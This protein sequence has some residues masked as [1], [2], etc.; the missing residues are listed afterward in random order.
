METPAY[1]DHR[2]HRGPSDSN[3]ANVEVTPIDE[4][5]RHGVSVTNDLARH[6]IFLRK[7]REKLN[8]GIRN[9][10]QQLA[11]A[12]GMLNKNVVSQGSIR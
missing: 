9:I 5:I 10:E 1:Q 11:E 7:E 2:I 6:L 3:V 4:M 8:D 12:S